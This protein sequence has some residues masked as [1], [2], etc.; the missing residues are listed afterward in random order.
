[1]GGGSASCADKGIA[2][3]K[4]VHLKDLWKYRHKLPLPVS[5]VEY[6]MGFPA[7]WTCYAG[8]ETPSPSPSPNLL[9]EEYSPAIDVESLV[10]R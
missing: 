7:N 8:W 9:E 4:Q 3:G 5:F 2:T 1:M 10:T 6:L